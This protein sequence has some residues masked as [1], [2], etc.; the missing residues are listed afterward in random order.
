M[1]T[2]KKGIIIGLVTASILGGGAGLSQLDVVKYE[3]DKL[4]KCKGKEIK[5]EETI[6]GKK[7][8]ICGNS[9]YILNLKQQAINKLKNNEMKSGKDNDFAIMAIL[10]KNDKGFRKSAL[11]EVVKKYDPVKKEFQGSMFDLDVRQQLMLY[12]LMAN[13]EYCQNGCQLRGSN[14][15]ERI[16]NL[17][18]K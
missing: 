9:G 11:D 1:E 4:V 17:I 15:N 8:Y 6:N 5:Y 10:A 2:A 13:W 14:A 7:G 18:K 12:A 3:A 16:Y